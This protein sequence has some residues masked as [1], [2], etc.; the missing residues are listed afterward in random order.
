[1][2]IWKTQSLLTVLPAL[3]ALL[4][5]SCGAAA[6]SSCNPNNLNSTT[7]LYPVTAPNTTMLSIAAATNR[8]FYD[9]ARQNLMADHNPQRGPTDPHTPP[10]LHPDNDTCL[11]SNAT[12]TRTCISGGPRNYYT[13]NGDTYEIIARRLNITTESLTALAL[14]PDAPDPND[15]LSPGQ[16]IKVTLCEP[17]QCAIIPY[18][19]TWG[20]YQDLAEELGTTVGQIMMLSPTYNYSSGAFLSGGSFP[21]IS[22]LVNCTEE[23]GGETV[24]T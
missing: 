3:P 13:V 7:Y 4:G 8:G 9:I 5:F 20:G 19:Y 6:S 14:G 10:N 23:T 18:Q 17:S 16:F 11:L 24:L 22:V 1:M 21:S 12:R 2:K 15:T